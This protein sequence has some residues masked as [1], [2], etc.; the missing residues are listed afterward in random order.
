VI[1]HCRAQFT[2]SS[3]VEKI[4]KS[5]AYFSCSSVSSAPMRLSRARARKPVAV[6]WGDAS[7]LAFSYKK[8]TVNH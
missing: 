4:P 2:A 6:I 7:M 3:E 8:F 1:A 5:G